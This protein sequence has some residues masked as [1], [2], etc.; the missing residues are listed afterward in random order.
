MILVPDSSLLGTLQRRRSLQNQQHHDDDN[1]GTLQR[2]RLSQHQEQQYDDNNDNDNDND[3]KNIMNTYHHHHDNNIKNHNNTFYYNSEVSDK[4][5]ES[6]SSISQ[7]S[8]ASSSFHVSQHSPLKKTYQ[9]DTTHENITEVDH[10]DDCDEDIDNS[11][12]SYDYNDDN[13]LNGINMMEEGIV[14][15]TTTTTTQDHDIKTTTWSKQTA[16]PN[17]SSLQN[18]KSIKNNH[19]SPYSIHSNNNEN[20]ETNTFHDSGVGAFPNDCINSISSSSSSSSSSSNS[21]D[22]E[23]IVFENNHQYN[24]NYDD[25]NNSYEYDKT[26]S[27]SYQ[28]Q[29]ENNNSNVT[30]ADYS[31]DQE[32]SCS[33][34]FQ[35]QQL[36]IFRQQQQK[37]RKWFGLL[38]RQDSDNTIQTSHSKKSTITSA[39][40]SALKKK[41][42]Q[43]AE[44]ENKRVMY[45]RCIIFI[46]LLV[47]CIIVS[48][49]VYK[50]TQN[51]E[52]TEFYNQYTL[53]SY[54]II[55]SIGMKLD[56]T[57]SS[58]DSFS[59]SLCTDVI[60]SNQSWPYI[61]LTQ[62]P[63]RAAK[64]KSMSS[65]LLGGIFIET[66]ILIQ[67][68]QRTSWENYSY[69]NG[70]SW[71]NDSLLIQNTDP[72]YY[73]PKEIDMNDINL[74]QCIYGDFGDI[75]YNIT[76]VPIFD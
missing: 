56:T 35:L 74:T 22:D 20:L 26:M 53:H 38:F 54:K 15:T 29:N 34:A 63:I 18:V 69:T 75:P 30:I 55:E 17:H 49:I 70:I 16:V 21:D 41:K 73:G 36:N 57:L 24:N 58:L 33:K 5:T 42:K 48:I 51:N 19:N 47:S 68:D 7:P 44:K 11:R 39:S 9:H 76:Y 2:R 23:E 14:S 72:N 28:R 67:N 65:N 4:T 52:Y 10:D 45:I 43:I 31:Q 60:I 46:L 71:I 3:R 8:L 61:T 64:Y 66:S 6:S 27:S 59:I 40:S 62:Y 37:Q 25:D 12:Y 1:E 32:Q 13:L 50:I